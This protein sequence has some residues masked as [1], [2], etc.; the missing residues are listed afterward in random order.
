MT[1]RSL[2]TSETGQARAKQA[3]LCKGWTQDYLATEAGLSTRNSVWKF[4]SGRPIDRNIFME[5]CFQLD[6]DWQDLADLPKPT[7]IP[8][9][10]PS[11][12][13]EL[14]PVTPN[15]PPEN[16]FSL[17]KEKGRSLIQNQCGTLQ[18]YFDVSQ[19]LPLE[20]VYTSLNILS[21][22]TNQQWLE[23]SDLQERYSPQDRLSFVQ[24][25][26]KNTPAIAAVT[27]QIRLVILGKPGTGKT[28]FLKHLALQCYQESQPLDY[29]PIFISLRNFANYCQEYDDFS[30]LNYIIHFLKSS[31]IS[32]EEIQ[33]L[34][35]QEKVLLLLDALDEIPQADNEEILQAIQQFTEIYHQNRLVIT[36]RIASQAYRFQNF[37]YVELANFSQAQIKDFAQRWFTATLQNT[38]KGLEKS[39]QFLE[40]LNRKENQPIRELAQTPILLAL[41]CSV[42]QERS[43]FPSKRSRLYQEGLEI[44]LSRWD[45]SRGITRDQ[46]Y[47]DLSLVDKL[48]LLSAI[49]ATMFEQE[50]YFFEQSD[51]LEIIVN[52]LATLPNPESDP[53][54]LWLNSEAILRA[55]ETQHGLIVERAKGIYG[56]SHLTFQEYLTA[57]KIVATP[58][59]EVLQQSLQSLAVQMTVPQWR[60]VILLTVEMLPNGDFLLRQMQTQVDNL[61]AGDSQLQLLLKSLDT[62]AKTLQ[63]PYPEVAVRAFYLG[64]D[65]LRDLNLA[66]A[67]DRELSGN[68]AA[69]L[70]LDVA[71]MRILT[72]SL[73]ITA[74]PDWEKILDLGFALDIER[75]FPMSDVLGRSLQNLKQQ[76]PNPTEGIE[77]LLSWWQT[78]GQEWCE[79]FRAFLV[80]DRHI[81]HDWQFSHRQ[82]ALLDQYYSANLFLVECLGQ[83]SPT[84][85]KAIASNLLMAEGE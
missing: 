84:K 65:Y 55:I 49:A 37:S 35:K 75:R 18:C 20:K 46:F 57:R 6:L 59:P 66:S 67:L 13:Q 63:T 14:P 39:A 27:Q 4:L 77:N 1:K 30:L 42:F 8:D 38:E 71:L 15:L 2:K 81:G 26:Q 78:K 24:T 23:V 47:G 22:L 9:P 69:E 36:C 31:E 83:V 48:K 85:R 16:L 54:T 34:F 32:Q 79:Q 11:V 44:L 64:L 7:P 51:L 68:L 28:T 76:L 53:E 60:E 58:T 3:M 72:L 52:F 82:K 43:K 40:N 17:V 45:Q 74:R 61:L 41:I 5:L 50:Q 62:K 25:L 19:P 21:R 73:S 29:F 33:D 80:E 12:T 10:L 56:F 70:A